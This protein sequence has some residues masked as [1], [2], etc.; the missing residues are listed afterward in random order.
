M[1]CWN[2]HRAHV[3]TQKFKTSFSPFR[4][5]FVAFKRPRLLIQISKNC[6]AHTSILVLLLQIPM[7]EW[8]SPF[9]LLFYMSFIA[10][11]P[12]NPDGVRVLNTRPHRIAS[13]SVYAPSSLQDKRGPPLQAPFLGTV[14]LFEHY[15]SKY[16]RILAG[17]FNTSLY[18]NHLDIAVKSL[19]PPKLDEDLSFMAKFPRTMNYTLFQQCFV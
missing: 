7:L 9:P 6:R 15:K 11:I 18:S 12:G 8:A 17:V 2:F 14:P 10:S 5:E 1:E 16:I 13:F 19:S 4:Q 3:D